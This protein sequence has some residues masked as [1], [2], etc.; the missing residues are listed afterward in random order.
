M[1][2]EQVKRIKD[3]VRLPERSTAGS[4]GYDFFAVEETTILP[5]AE[6]SKPTM[7]RTGVK[8]QLDEGKFL[9]LANR[10]SN[11]KKLN[12]VIPN[13]VGVIDEDYYNNEDN[14][15]EIAFTFYNVGEEPVTLKPGDKLGQGLIMS[16]YV[17]EDDQA[18][19]VRTGGFGSTGK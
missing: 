13:S 6:N 4:A 8:V 7:V 10:S 1:K 9:M 15:G 2:F 18:D 17:V 5:F 3:T 16:Y 11:P 19:G 14:E 12:L